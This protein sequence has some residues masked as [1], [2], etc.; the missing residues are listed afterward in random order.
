M[1]HFGTRFSPSSCMFMICFRSLL[2]WRLP[3]CWG[4]GR[5]GRKWDWIGYQNL[6]LGRGM[7]YSVAIPPHP[8]PCACLARHTL[9][10][11]HTLEIFF[12]LLSLY[13]FDLPVASLGRR[14]WGFFLRR[15]SIDMK[16][17]FGLVLMRSCSVACLLEYMVS[18]ALCCRLDGRVCGI[19]TYIHL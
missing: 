16:W 15:L 7:G 19:H 18:V 6:G 2:A 13:L 9:T 11:L 10:H 4:P 17:F 1:L 5:L 14:E 3:Y 12:F 8:F